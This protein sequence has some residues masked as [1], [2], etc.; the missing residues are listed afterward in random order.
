L[1]VVVLVAEISQR[2]LYDTRVIFIAIYLHKLRRSGH[3]LSFLPSGK[4]IIGFG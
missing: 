3:P 4:A 1:R 2:I